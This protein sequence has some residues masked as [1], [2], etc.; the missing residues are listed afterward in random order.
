MLNNHGKINIVVILLIV[1][2]QILI[3]GG[4]YVYLV[5]MKNPAA[6]QPLALLPAGELPP[7]TDVKPTRPTTPPTQ[8]PAQQPQSNLPNQPSTRP[9]GT[10]SG[11]SFIDDSNRDYGGKDYVKDFALYALGDVTVN[12]KGSTGFLMVTISFEYR[13]TD[14]NLP[15]EL[16]N[17][18]A[19]FK[20]RL[21]SYFGN[22]TIDDLKEI[23]NRSIFKDDIMRLINGL[24]IQGRIT[25]V[26]F[27]QFL[28]QA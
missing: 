19:V 25:S 9:T 8:P 20:D 14:V 7:P 22:L 5:Y 24:L 4:L 6:E 2:V 28:I 15:A 1:V 10:G 21:T 26:I 18:T 11:N 16:K 3:C 12:P 23:D 13:L 27:D 17:K